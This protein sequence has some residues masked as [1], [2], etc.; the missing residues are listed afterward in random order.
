M[1]RARWLRMGIA[2]AVSSEILIHD[3]VSHERSDG[4]DDL[5][6]R[7][8]VFGVGRSRPREERHPIDFVTN[9]EPVDPGND[10]INHAG[11]IPPEREWRLA[12]APGIR[13]IERQ[14]RSS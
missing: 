14:H 4:E 12:E 9:L 2:S 7:A 10:F 1:T 3:R 5:S 6:F 8:T 13:P 11:D